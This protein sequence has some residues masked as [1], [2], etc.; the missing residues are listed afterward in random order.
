M[1]AKQ[2]L[3][4]RSTNIPSPLKSPSKIPLPPSPEKSRVKPT[5]FAEETGPMDDIFKAS[6]LSQ[7]P[8]LVKQIA[9]AHSIGQTYNSPSDEISSPTTKKLSE[10]KGR[11]MGWVDLLGCDVVL[12]SPEILR[13]LS[14]TRRTSLQKPG[15]W[16]IRR[17]Q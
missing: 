6:T 17:I 4:E 3:T 8:D 10:V 11:R 1:A 5:V 2:P 12:T 9:A 15:R 14:T 13:S 16:R 7:K